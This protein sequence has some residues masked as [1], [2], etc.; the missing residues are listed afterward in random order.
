M[1]SLSI[2]HRHLS[3][4]K[5]RTVYTFAVLITQSGLNRTLWEHS[6][7]V[8]IIAFTAADAV[9]AIRDSLLGKVDYPTEIE[10]MGPKGGKLGRFIGWETMIGA[11]MFSA[12][13]NQMEF[14]LN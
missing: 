14:S 2:P 6:A 7:L 11:Q 8:H 9:N 13:S 3:K 12:R 1:K 5:G 10:T 4:Y